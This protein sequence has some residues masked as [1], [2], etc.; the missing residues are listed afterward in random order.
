MRRIAKENLLIMVSLVIFITPFQ[1]NAAEPTAVALIK[2]AIWY[3]TEG[4]PAMQ[5]ALGH[6]GFSAAR[7]SVPFT[8]ENIT[9]DAIEVTVESP[10]CDSWT[11]TLKAGWWQEYAC[12]SGSGDTEYYVSYQNEFFNINGGTYNVL[13]EQHDRVVLVDYT[14]RAVETYKENES[15]KPVGR[16]GSRSSVYIRKDGRL[17]DQP[18]GQKFRG[19][20]KDTA[21][22]DVP[23]GLEETDWEIRFQPRG[24]SFDR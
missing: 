22:F 17:T 11:M 14:R 24:R 2:A 21:Q 10:T 20:L 18:T 19:S 4:G 7:P 9:S 5:K 12:N 15:E 8:I 3:I 23:P 16:G 1:S 13:K 6:K